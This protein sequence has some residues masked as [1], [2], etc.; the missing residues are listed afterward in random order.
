MNPHSTGDAGRIIS[1]IA[2]GGYTVKFRG[3]NALDIYMGLPP[4]PYTWLE[5]DADIAALARLV[6]DLRFP[7]VEI[8]DGAVESAGSACYFRCTDNFESA[9]LGQP[10]SLPLLSFEYDCLT[11]HFYD[12]LGVYP[13]LREL[14][15]RRGYFTDPDALQPKAIEITQE[16]F[17]PPGQ[18]INRTGAGRNRL[19]MDAALL[20]A[21]YG[22]DIDK[23]PYSPDKL[24]EIL[25]NCPVDSLPELEIQKAFL[26]CLLV[27][28][29]PDWGFE[30]IKK[31]GLLEEIWP[32]LASFDNVDHAKE[33]HPEGNVW[34]HT[35]ETFRHR[36]APASGAFDLRLSLGLL[37][38]DSGK[39]IADANRSR[40]FDGHAELGAQAA[41]RFL[42]RLGFDN[43]ISEDVFYLVR[44]H[45]LPAAL[46]RLP[47][48]KTAEIMASPLFPTL[49]EL[50]RCDEASSFKGLDGYYE[51]SAAYQAYLKNSR[52]PY[53]SMDGKKIGR[54]EIYSRL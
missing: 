34:N 52:N 15:D 21:R 35:L 16:R 18:K 17:K 39:P 25:K 24:S 42:D 19:I 9:P 2:A 5:T 53:R 4:L 49:M 46:K 11:E 41:R 30:L 33:F 40:R 45:M 36:K 51:N 10:Y 43:E 37:L 54:R 6:D 28:P 29:R 44:N 38:H 32:E 47:L 14:R 50:Y 7:G 12:P 48:S 26:V 20:L 22:F 3:F 1:S 13:L 27:S 31:H 23:S 8:A